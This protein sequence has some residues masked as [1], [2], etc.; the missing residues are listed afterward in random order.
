VKRL[1]AI[2]SCQAHSDRVKAQFATWIRDMTT[3]IFVFSFTG[4]FLGISDDYAALPQKTQAICK[5]ALGMSTEYLLKIDTDTYVHPAR[6]MASGFEKYDYSGYVLDW[7]ETPYCAGPAYWLSRKAMELVAAADLSQF[8]HA[9]YPDAEDV[10]VGL[11]LASHG[12][13]PHHD[14]RYAPQ[15]DVLP[16]N[17]VITSHLSRHHGG[18]KLEMMFEAHERANG[19]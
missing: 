7:L 14:R 2:E 5:W 1:I 18:F 17:D 13:K 9:S 3:E 11:I 15:E 12:I 16:E 6:L 10:T 8:R 19:R 4:E